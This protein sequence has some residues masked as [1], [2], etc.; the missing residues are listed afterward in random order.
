M[1]EMNKEMKQLIR[2]I[3]KRLLL[4]LKPTKKAIIPMIG[5]VGGIVIVYSLEIEPISLTGLVIPIITMIFGMA[6]RDIISFYRKRKLDE[7]ERYK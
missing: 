4:S 7:L 5:L 2:S 1:K 3:P 6:C